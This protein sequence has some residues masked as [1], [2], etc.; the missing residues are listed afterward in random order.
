[1]PKLNYEAKHRIDNVGGVVLKQ[2]DVIAMDSEAAAP[3]VSSG[4]L[5]ETEA[6]PAA[7][8]SKSGK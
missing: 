8:D 7:A 2:G 3:L 5:T 6:K 4:A 1:M